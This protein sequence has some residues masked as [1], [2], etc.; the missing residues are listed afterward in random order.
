M[1]K[2]VS[3]ILM[4]AVF[5]GLAGLAYTGLHQAFGST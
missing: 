1:K 3:K 5:G 4:F 2:R